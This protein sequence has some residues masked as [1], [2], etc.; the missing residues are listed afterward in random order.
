MSK[1][2]EKVKDKRKGQTWV[3]QAE[4]MAGYPISIC[5]K[6]ITDV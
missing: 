5:D 1:G 4:I 3:C 2:L 6:I